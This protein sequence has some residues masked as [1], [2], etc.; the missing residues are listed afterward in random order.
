M[1]FLFRLTLLGGQLLGLCLLQLGNLG[2]GL[3]AKGGSTPVLADFFRALVEVG[4]HGLDK[5]VEGTL[6][7]GLDLEEGRL[8]Y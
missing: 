3:V 2:E 7:L 1:T 5:L 6:V 8:N 4:L